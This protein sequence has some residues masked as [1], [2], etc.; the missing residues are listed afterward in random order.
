MYHSK[1]IWRGL[2][3][4]KIKLVEPSLS[5]ENQI[6]SYR[7]EFLVYQDSMDGTS[8]LSEFTDIEKWLACIEK[9]SY[10]ETVPEGLVTAT[11]FLVIREID[12]KLV[13]MVSIRHTL[14]DYLFKLGGHIG[15]SVRRSERNQGYAKEILA[16]SLR[17]CKTLKL[18]RVL[19]T[20][21][22][23]NLASA[24]VIKFNGGILESEFFDEKEQEIIQRYWIVL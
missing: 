4:K 10:E 14:N 18:E 22:K 24:K 23:S 9:K 19:L 2:F 13:G 20:C 21:D 6:L 17:Y 16:Q 7:E 3:M 1:S 12:S 8:C 11:E 15:Y 5:S